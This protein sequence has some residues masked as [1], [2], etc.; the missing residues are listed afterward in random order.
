MNP[1][2]GPR[3]ADPATE[4]PAE[5]SGR[6]R[7]VLAVAGGLLGA[8]AVVGA[9]FAFGAGDSDDTALATG[10]APAAPVP[11]A[12]PAPTP[13]APATPDPLIGSTGVDPFEPLVV[14]PVPVAS[15][16]PTTVPTTAPTTGIG[17]GW[18]DWNDGT[19]GTGSGSG[20][21]SPPLPYPT[22]VP[23]T[24]PTTVPSPTSSPA[25]TTVS[26]RVVSVDDDNTGATVEVDGTKHEVGLGE[27]FGDGFTLLRLADGECATF[28]HGEKFDLCEGDT[29]EHTVN[30]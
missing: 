14:P 2:F 3:P 17:D 18:D 15:T 5:T 10:A 26:L 25:P 19:G 30:H 20:P 24:A 12:T 27:Q 16:A 28:D 8:T 22:T 1:T 11:A 4:E 13:S 29:T 23:T 6:S 21:V 9:W 7:V